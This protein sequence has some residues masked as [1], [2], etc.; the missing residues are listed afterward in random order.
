MS[1]EIRIAKA[2]LARYFSVNS[3]VWVRNAGPMDEA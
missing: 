1:K 2:K 3:D